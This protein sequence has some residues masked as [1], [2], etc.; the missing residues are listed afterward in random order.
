MFK[1]IMAWSLGPNEENMG[2]EGI[3]S[4]FIV[5]YFAMFQRL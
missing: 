4:V 3:S 2:R 5:V 1:N